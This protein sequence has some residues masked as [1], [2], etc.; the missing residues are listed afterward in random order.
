[1][2]Q[3]MV[4]EFVREGARVF[5][6]DLPDTPLAALKDRHGDAIRTAVIDVRD[7]AAWARANVTIAEQMGPLDVL[8]NNAGIS[9]TGAP[10]DPERIKLDQWRAIHL[11]NVEGVVL[12]CQAAIH[13]M[14]GRGGSIVNISS[15]AALNPS[16]KMIAYGASKAAVRHITRTVAAYCAQ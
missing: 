12:G 10:Q 4:A 2:G 13:A 7:E 3:V 5:A 9:Q 8:V 16:P 14:K 6:T 15:V 1:F 11:V